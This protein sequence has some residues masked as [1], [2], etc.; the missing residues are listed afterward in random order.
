MKKSHILI[1]IIIAAAIGIVVTTADDASTYVTFDQA[2]ELASNGSKNSIHVVGELK[3][4]GSGHVLGIEPGADR[5]SFSFI[6]VDQNQKEQ[7]VIYNEPMP[8][9]FTRSEKVVVIGS[10]QGDTFVADKI[11]LKCPSKYQEQNLNAKI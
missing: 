1:I 7:Q 4:D 3:K 8:Q 2:H 9:D 10:F 6:M 5:V 11:L